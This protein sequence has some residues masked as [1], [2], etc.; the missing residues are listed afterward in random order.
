MTDAIRKSLDRVGELPV[1]K[2]LLEMRAAIRGDLLHARAGAELEYAHHV[3]KPL[4]LFAQGWAG[5]DWMV[6]SKP[7]F[8]YEALAGMRWVF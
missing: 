8:G 5:L 3:S 4:S 7:R 1:G 2:G 6:G